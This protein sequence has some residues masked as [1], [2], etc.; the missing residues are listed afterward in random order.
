MLIFWRLVLGHLIADFTLQSNFVN[1]W[2]RSNVMGMLFHSGMHPVVNLLLTYRYL[3]DYWVDNQYFRLQGWACVLIIFITHFIEDQWRVF[4][5]FKFHTSDN[6]L[7]FVWDQFIHYAVIFMVF[8]L[9]ML[10]GGGMQ[11][12]IPERWVIL[13]ILFV[14]V[15]HFTTVMIYFLEKD[16]FNGVFPDF[17]AKYL[18]MAERLV[19]CLCFFLPGRLWFPM[20]LAWTAYLVYLKLRRI[21]DITWFNMAVGAVASVLCGFVGRAVYFT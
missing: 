17:D 8:P 18:G 13:G 14:L 16:F 20:A 10:T 5:I 4:T 3:G 12:P 15:T 6:T 19:L 2:K 1:H 21:Q 9:E 11:R 7:Y